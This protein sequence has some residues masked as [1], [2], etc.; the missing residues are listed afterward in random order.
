MD[1]NAKRYYDIRIKSQDREIADRDAD[2]KD[3]NFFNVDKRHK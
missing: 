3:D 2:L 1:D